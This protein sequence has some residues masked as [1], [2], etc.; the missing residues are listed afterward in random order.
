MEKQCLSEVNSNDNKSKIKL[1]K[2]LCGT[3]AE[4]FSRIEEICSEQIEEVSE[5]S[6]FGQS[7][8][9]G[10][11]LYIKENKEAMK[12]KYSAFMD[13]EILSILLAKW[14]KLSET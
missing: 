2:K 8:G 10:M 12:M 1:I 14:H 5:P 11:Y 9:I 6:L 7:E 13:N 3:I 4:A